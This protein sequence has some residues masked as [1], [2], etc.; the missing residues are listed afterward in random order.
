MKRSIL[1]ASGALSLAAVVLVAGHVRAE[2]DPIVERRAI[3]KSWGNAT[4]DPGKMLRG[5][6]SFDLAK[7]QSLLKLIGDSAPKLQALFPDSSKNGDTKALPAVWEKK[8]A[9]EAIY[10]KIATDATAAAAGIKDEATFKA[11]LP[12][13]LGNCSACHNDFRAK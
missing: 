1:A 2:G 5:E 4:R 9:F 13:V 3:L 10:T 8:A 6:E 7:V 12:K 11:Q